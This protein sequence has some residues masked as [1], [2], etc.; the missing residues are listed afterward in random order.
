MPKAGLL[1]GARAQGISREV[2]QAGPANYQSGARPTIT[3]NRIK[4]IDRLVELRITGQYDVEAVDITDNVVT[5]RVNQYDYDAAVDGVAV[6]V[7]DATDLS[8]QTVTLV[9]EGH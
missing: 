6:E 1:V 4:T 7:P 8:A 2:S 9:V 3:V 5:Y